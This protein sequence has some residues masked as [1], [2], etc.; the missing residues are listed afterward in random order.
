MMAPKGAEFLFARREIQPMIV[1]LAISWG[2]GSDN[3]FE[4]GS[5]FLDSLQWMGT[6]DPSGFLSVPAAIAFLEEHAWGS[7][8]DRC[9]VLLH[10]ALERLHVEMELPALAPPGICSAPQMAAVQLPPLTDPAGL[11][12]K[13]YQAH[14]VEIPVMVWQ[15]RP[16]LRLSVQGYNSA[17]DIKALIAALQAEL[18]A[19]TA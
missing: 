17:S 13:L 6:R 14:G 4:S 11:Q 1:P 2:W 10:Q 18:P 8:A 19:F 9:Q 3:P 5:R 15:R 16:L 7:A 12:A